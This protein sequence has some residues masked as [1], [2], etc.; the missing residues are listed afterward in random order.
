MGTLHEL[1]V[2]QG[3]IFLQQKVQFGLRES[4]VVLR[5]SVSTEVVGKHI[6]ATKERLCGTK[7]SIGFS[8]Y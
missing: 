4:L 2:Q 3:V 8:L 1:W 5:D 7:E 6:E